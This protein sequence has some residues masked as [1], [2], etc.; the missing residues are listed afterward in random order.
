[1]PYYG[2][3]AK[4][5][6]DDICLVPGV[7]QPGSKEPLSLTHPSHLR[8]HLH[9]FQV[10]ASVGVF[11]GKVMFGLRHFIMVCPT[12]L[13]LL[14]SVTRVPVAP[15]PWPLQGQNPADKRGI[16]P[17]GHVQGNLLRRGGWVPLQA[18]HLHYPLMNHFRNRG[19]LFRVSRVSH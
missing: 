1:M 10:R 15:A 14:P 13:S 9:C 3:C 2:R 18:S 4:A 7:K 17:R 5:S 16:G 11:G 8:A 12:S 6:S 19:S